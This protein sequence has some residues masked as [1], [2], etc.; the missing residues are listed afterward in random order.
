MPLPRDRFSSTPRPRD[1]TTHSQ[2]ASPPLAETTQ[3]GNHPHANNN[4]PSSS[5]VSRQVA[6]PLVA[7]TTASSAP[8]AVPRSVPDGEGIA[9]AAEQRGGAMLNTSEAAAE[10]R[11]ALQRVKAQQQALLARL[12][13]LEGSSTVSSVD[14]AQ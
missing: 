11:I 4:R 10:A 2:L 1:H 6:P 8:R 7:D 13:A 3:G 9:D 5:N 14:S 12:E